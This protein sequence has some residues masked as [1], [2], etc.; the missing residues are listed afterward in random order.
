MLSLV[1]DNWIG[2]LLCC[3][4]ATLTVYKYVDAVFRTLATA[5][6]SLFE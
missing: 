2:V 5:A 1:R 6:S 4:Y 3:D